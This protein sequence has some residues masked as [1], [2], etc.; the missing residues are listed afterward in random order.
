MNELEILVDDFCYRFQ[1]M[2]SETCIEYTK[3]KIRKK[4]FKTTLSEVLTILLI[5]E[6]LS[7]SK[8]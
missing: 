2:C 7:I 5:K 8:C 6:H 4:T 1:E 3:R